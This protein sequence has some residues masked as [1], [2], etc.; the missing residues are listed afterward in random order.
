MITWTMRQGRWGQGFRGVSLAAVEYHRRRQIPLV[1]NVHPWEIDPGQ[2]SVGFS[3]L[4]KWAHYAR[5]DH[6][7][8]ILG[9]VLQLARFSTIE[10]R[11]RELALLTS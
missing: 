11:L 3:R 4:A 2:P 6:T 9:R 5:L 7:H 8:R 1:V 10:T